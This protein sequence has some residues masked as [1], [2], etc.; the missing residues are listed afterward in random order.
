M[1][2]PW[3][4]RGASPP[5]AGSRSARLRNGAALG[6]HE[7]GFSRAG[8]RLVVEVAADYTVKLAFVTLFRYRM[9][10]RE[11]WEGGLLQSARASTDVNGKPERVTTATGRSLRSRDRAQGPTVR[12]P[13]HASPPTGIWTSSPDR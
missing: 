13:T 8:G 11:V 7:I 10:A 2:R 3:E 6:T 5:E 12:R 1:R 4:A 9:R